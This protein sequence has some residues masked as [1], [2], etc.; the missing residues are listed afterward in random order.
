[1]ADGWAAGRSLSAVLDDT[2]LTAGDFVRWVRQVV[3]FAGQIADAADP[4]GL[5]DVARQLVRTMRRG[6]VSYAPEIDSD[7]GDDLTGADLP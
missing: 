4:G 5:R 3:D 6:V 7:E 2:E 1:V